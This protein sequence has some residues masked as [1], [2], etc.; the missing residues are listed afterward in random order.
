MGKRLEDLTVSELKERL[1]DKNLP[2]GGTKEDLIER[3]RGKKIK[4]DNV[5]A[6][7]VDQ[8]LYLKI[9]NK[10]KKRVKAW[11]SAYASECL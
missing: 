2:T 9:K 8:K 3:L 1:R 5:P 4:G 10:I 6:N 7:V 11:P